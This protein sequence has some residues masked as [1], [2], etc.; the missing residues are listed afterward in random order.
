M[1]NVIKSKSLAASLCLTPFLALVFSSAAWSAEVKIGT[2]DMQRALQAVE[3]GK[4][5]KAQLEKEYNAKKEELLKKETAIK[6][7]T[8]EFQ[9]QTL[10]MSEEARAKRQA[11]LQQ[12]ILQFQQLTARSQTEIQQKE[13]ELFQPIFNKL[14]GVIAETAKRHEFTVILEKNEN[15]VLYSQEKDDMTNEVITTFD[16]QTKSGK[17]T[18]DAG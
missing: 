11:A 5:A 14:K 7:L 8:E 13:R 15:N 16:K 4:K 1:R 2:V 12:D 3:S 10:A 18:K 9:K 6:K 17:S